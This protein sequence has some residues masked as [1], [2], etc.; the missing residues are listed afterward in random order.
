MKIE[1]NE[2]IEA[3]ITEGYIASSFNVSGGPTKAIITLLRKND[4]TVAISTDKSGYMHYTAEE[5]GVP[6]SFHRNFIEI[7][8]WKGGSYEIKKEKTFQPS[9]SHALSLLSDVPHYSQINILD[10]IVLL[11]QK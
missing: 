7:E 8:K 5:N 9:V 2:L 3:F 10:F 6:V 1:L 11:S 4:L